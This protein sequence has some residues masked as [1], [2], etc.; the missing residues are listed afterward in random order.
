MKL[1]LHCEE[2]FTSQDWTCPACGFV[3]QI[4]EKRLSFVTPASGD[5]Y[6]PEFFAKLAQLE[7][8]HFWFAWRNRLII[9]VLRQFFP[10]LTNFL[11]VGCGTGFV[12]SAVAD[13]FPTAQVSGSEYFEEGLAFAAARLPQASFYQMDARRL[14]FVE[15]FDVIGAF[16]VLEHIVDDEA[17]LTQ[18]YRAVRPGGGIVLSVPQHR[19]LWSRTDE[20]ACH[21]RR[22]TR[23]ELLCKV[24][25]AGFRVEYHTSFVSL[26]LPA[27]AVSRRRRTQQD[28]RGPLCE[29]QL[30]ALLNAVF[31][32][33]MKLEFALTNAGLRLPAGGSLL[34]A[35]RK[36]G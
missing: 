29:L 24:E 6:R 33:V 30:P 11:E 20:E 31:S 32:T 18:A 27:L 3:P 10:K 23:R 17:V 4:S 7:A 36:V 21:V 25:M 8:G 35:G 9:R 12:L 5:G 14:P 15:E 22:Y 16:D 26:L 19:W 28:V 1:C 13:A 34:V 2:V